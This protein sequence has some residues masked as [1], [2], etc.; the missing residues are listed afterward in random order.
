MKRTLSAATLLTLFVCVSAYFSAAHSQV[1]VNSTTG[2]SVNITVVPV[3]VIPDRN[4]CP[5]GYNYNLRLRYNV[6]FSGSNIPSGGLW[7]FDGNIGCG[8][9][10]VYFDP[11]N[12]AGNGTVVTTSNPWRALTD[13]N[14][15]TVR[16]I[17]CN[18]GSIHIYGP[19]ISERTVSF[20]INYT[21]LP[22]TIAS[23]T[24]N[25]NN[26]RV[27]LKWS[28]ATEIDNDFFSI[29][30]S[31]NGSIWTNIGT[32][33]GAGNSSTLLNY[34]FIDNQPL[35]GTSFYRIKQTDFDGHY[36]YSETRQIQDAAVPGTIS[37]APVPSNGR[38]INV[39]GIS[40]YQGYELTLFNTA[41][42]QLFNKTLSNSSVTLPSLAKGVYM[43]R[44]S[45]SDKGEA[46][47]LRYVQL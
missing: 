42:A 23:F 16:S 44:I 45:N 8:S 32:V 35:T 22:I 36:S 37:I 9:Q 11:P 21:A 28:T 27:A 19:G 43:I 3:Q 5:N 34:Q 1:T 26:G 47:T 30:R 10:Q 13:C 40:N 7:T 24:A 18:T 39:A 6:S 20:A 46:Q 17:N 12:G 2:Y 4:P 29:E 41:G 33:D 31:V 25:A 14:G 38:T 15:A